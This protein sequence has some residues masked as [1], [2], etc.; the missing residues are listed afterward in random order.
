ML[1]TRCPVEKWVTKYSVWPEFPSQLSL[2]LCLQ[3]LLLFYIHFGT[4]VLLSSIR[5]EVEQHQACDI[6]MA[7][8][9]FHIKGYA[10]HDFVWLLN[11]SQYSHQR[12]FRTL[13]FL[14]DIL[15]K[16]GLVIQSNCDIWYMSETDPIYSIVKP[17]K[18]D[19][20]CIFRYLSLPSHRRSTISY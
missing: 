7:L 6:N 10:P 4:H 17:M 20:L 5:G 19:H 15:F 1:W 14:L 3:L 16:P 12:S 13:L 18:S 2:T 8:F 11:Q 9:F